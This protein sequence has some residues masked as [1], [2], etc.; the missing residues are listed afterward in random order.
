[1]DSGEKPRKVQ[2]AGWGDLSK[3]FQG[4]RYSDCGLDVGRWETGAGWTRP[5]DFTDFLSLRE[6]YGW[7]ES[8][9]GSVKPTV[10]SRVPI[11]P[12]PRPMLL[13]SGHCLSEPAAGGD[14]AAH[15]TQGVAM[16]A[17]D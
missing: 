4:V 3:K 9:Q 12:R 1:M 10:Q 6:G 5:L 14:K 16:S 17:L 15:A 11:C 2:L 8:Q 13:T 7:G